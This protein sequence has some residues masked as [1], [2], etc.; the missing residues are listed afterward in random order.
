MENSH[1]QKK[2]CKKHPL[3]KE[4]KAKN[5]ELSKRRIY[6]EHVNRFIKRFKI[7]STVYRNKGKNSN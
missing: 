1:Y 4:D 5:R 7:I 6:V 2:S 3:T